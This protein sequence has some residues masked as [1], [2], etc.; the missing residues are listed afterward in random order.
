[1]NFPNNDVIEPCLSVVMPVYNEEPTVLQVISSVLAQRPVQELIVVDDCSRDGTWEKLQTVTDPR[2][3]IFKH[4]VNQ[5]KGAAVRTTIQE[6]LSGTG[7]YGTKI[8]RGRLWRVAGLQGSSPSRTCMGWRIICCWQRL[9]L[10]GRWILTAAR[11]ISFC[12]PVH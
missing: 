1:M 11:E 7:S 4:E 5:G 9:R 8:G 12:L 6:H 2:V 10:S 3:R